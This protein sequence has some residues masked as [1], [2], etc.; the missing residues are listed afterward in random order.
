MLA[1]DAMD[2]FALDVRVVTDTGPG[3]APTPC[4]TDD[5]CAATCASSCASNV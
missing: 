2:I 5:G 1:T 3:E 4:S